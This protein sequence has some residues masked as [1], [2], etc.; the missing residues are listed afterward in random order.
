MLHLE[1]KASQ[2]PAHPF[3][4]SGKVCRSVYLVYS[5]L[6]LYL[7]GSLVHLRESRTLYYMR[8]LE[9]YANGEA[10]GKTNYRKANKRFNK[11]YH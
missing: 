4:F 2:H 5:P 8:Q 6:L 10:A 3:V 1:V 11:A 7:L 9:Y